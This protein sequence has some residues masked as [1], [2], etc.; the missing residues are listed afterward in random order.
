MSE[1]LES[2]LNSLPTVQSEWR[3]PEEYRLSDPVDRKILESRYD[4]NRIATKH[5]RIGLT[6]QELSCLRQPEITDEHRSVAEFANDLLEQGSRYGSWFLF[7]WSGQLVHFPTQDDLFRLRTAR[8]RNLITEDEQKRLY[9][10]TIAVFGLS[11]GSNVVKA[12]V[13]SGIGNKFILADPDIIEPTNLNRIDASFSEI[14]DRKIDHVA[15]K[16]SEIDPYIE[17][18]HFEDGV[19]RSAL[20]QISDEH[21]P[22]V[23]ID[24][25]DNVPIKVANREEGYLSKTP[26]I[27]GTDLGDKPIIDVERYDKEP[28]KAFNGR[29][30]DKD[31]RALIDDPDP[32]VIKKS[33]SKIIGLTNV[34]PRLVDSV[35]EQGKSLSGF[36][37]LEA[38]AL[39]V[40]ALVT[41]VTREIL[42]DR[43]LESGRYVFSPKNMFGL[44]SPTSLPEAIRILTRFA[45]LDKN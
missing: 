18:V 43:K 35:I 15:K 29:L 8:N 25:V 38:T 3:K 14:G 4:N 33:L 16:I 24:E 31:L 10:S 20:R 19:D 23:L 2:K 39:M 44:D 27:M 36:P 37:Q 7:P 17:Q 42:L 40:G 9:A 32:Q 34:T 30:K 1:M 21:K 28:V 5:D 11:V 12:M 45:L 26:V 6:V 22:D 41:L 13:L